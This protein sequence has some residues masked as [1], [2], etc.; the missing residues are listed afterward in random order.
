MA[1]GTVNPPRVDTTLGRVLAYRPWSSGVSNTLG[2]ESFKRM[3]S[4]D[5]AGHEQF[6]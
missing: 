1:P 2:Q 6:T 5:K 3:W 4:G